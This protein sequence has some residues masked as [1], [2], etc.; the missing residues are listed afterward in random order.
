MAAAGNGVWGWYEVVLGREV[1]SPCV[2]DLF[3]L[4][5]APPAIVGLLVLAIPRR[6]HGDERRA[7]PPVPQM[8][9]PLPHP[10][11]GLRRLPGV[12]LLPLQLVN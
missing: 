9:P 4:C 6:A 1:P 3:F 10:A 12:R 11:G 2:A 8:R 7:G 5:F